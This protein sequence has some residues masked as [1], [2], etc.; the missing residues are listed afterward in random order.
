MLIPDRGFQLSISISGHTPSIGVSSKWIGAITLEEETLFKQAQDCLGSLVV[1]SDLQVPLHRRA[2]VE[3][4]GDIIME[5]GL[6]SAWKAYLEGVDGPIRSLQDLVD[7]HAKH[8]VSSRSS[9]HDK[10]QLSRSRSRFIPITQ[11][12]HCWL[13]L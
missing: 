8:P 5:V 4:C 13:T 1:A 11:D 6:K 10:V 12:S 7:W 3:G 2:K 9:R